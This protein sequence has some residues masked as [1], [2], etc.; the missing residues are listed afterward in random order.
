LAHGRPATL[1]TLLDGP[2]AGRMLAVTDEATVGD[3]GRG[4]GLNGAVAGDAAALLAQGVS[5]LRRFGAD[6]TRMGEDLAVFIRSFGEAPRIVVVGAV[7]FAVAVSRMAREMGYR[8][9]VCDPR[10]PFVSGSRLREAAEVAVA[11][12]DEYLDGQELG[13]RDAVLIFTHDPKFDEPAALAALRSGAGYI[14]AMGSRKTN[15]ERRERLR[16]LG[17]TDEGLRRIS[18]PCGLDIG[19][20]TPPE[21]AVSILAEI[22]ALRTGRDGGRLAAA[23]GPIRDRQTSPELIGDAA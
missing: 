9:T 21:T 11:W 13:P 22:T 8:V 2:S 20:S 15:R 7:D 19:G 14:G 23:S 12:P 16:E 10:E 6:G 18:S 3:L 17:V 4:T 1:V 5:M